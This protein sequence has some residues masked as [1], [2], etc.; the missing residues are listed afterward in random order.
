M[1]L[2][3]N[4]EEIK[5]QIL[6]AYERLSTQKPLTQI[7]LREIAAEAG[8]SHTK[9]LRYFHDKNSLYIE[10]A[11]WASDLMVRDVREWLETHTFRDYPNEKAFLD[12]LFQDVRCA[13]S[14]SVSPRDVMMT[15]A[16]AAYDERLKAVIQ[17]AYLLLGEVFRAHL[18]AAFGRKLTEQEICAIVVL[19]NGVYFSAANESLLNPFGTPVLETLAGL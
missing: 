5:L 6:E 9:V 3:V 15:C 1:P 12:G 17:E 19:F 8:M 10:S 7:S 2:V 4:K 11:R 18:E 14:G 16:L 13:G